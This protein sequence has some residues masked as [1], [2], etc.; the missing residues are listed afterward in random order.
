[1]R[2]S[3]LAMMVALASWQGGSVAAPA[4]KPAKSEIQ[5]HMRQHFAAASELQR[6][7]ITGRLADAKELAR[8]L[9]THSMAELD[10]WTPY[11]DEMRFAAR[12]IEAAGDVPTAA[13]LIGR[14]GRACSACHEAQ[15]AK[16]SFAPMTPPLGGNTLEAQMRR[17]QW[18]AERMWE[19]VIGPSDARWAAGARMLAMTRFDVRKAVHEKPNVDV[20]ELA[21]RL[22]VVGK[23]AGELRDHD[24][25]A[26]FYGEMMATCTGCHA[27]ARPRP[28]VE[29]KR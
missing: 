20:I 10:G 11:V 22:R 24:T 23:Q 3:T 2:T 9:A 7:V 27:I 8:W 13:S 18:A 4:H 15:R 12:E 16:V 25:Q 21:E 29:A 19:G 1:M 14:L 17:H 26:V 5:A 6:A 28:V